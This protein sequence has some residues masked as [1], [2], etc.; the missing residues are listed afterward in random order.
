MGICIDRDY[1]K[2]VFTEYTDKY[3]SSDT[4]IKLK[5]DHTF[6]VAGLSE[7][8]AKSINLPADDVDIAWLVG[9]LH[10]IGR[11]EQVRIYNTF[12]D[13]DSIDHAHFGADLLFKDKLI[14][15]FLGR[16]TT[17]AVSENV[18]TMDALSTIELA[19]RNHSAYRIQSGLSERDIMFCGIIRD[20]DKIDILK[21]NSDLPIEE[22]YNVTTEELKNA[23]V[24]KEVLEAFYE[25][26]AVLRKL[27]KTPV[28]HIVGHISLAY[29]LVY[30]MSYKLLSSQGYIYK[31]MNFNS[32][33]PDTMKD[34]EG[35]RE[36]MNKYIEQKEKLINA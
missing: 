28:D 14:E 8:I 2:R 26:H 13:A 22:I 6:R 10:D 34:F 17:D 25:E 23:Q 3:D 21:V 16:N 15:L 1:I 4:K 33:N 35:I 31:I 24:T 7:Q 18:I 30:P 27:K 20:A 12:S 19:I 32:Y 5:I 36:H 29:E 11:F 9:M